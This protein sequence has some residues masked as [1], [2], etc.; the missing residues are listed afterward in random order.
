MGLGDIPKGQATLQ[1]RFLTAGMLISQQPWA[2]S[3]AQGLNMR[4]NRSERMVETSG[5][6]G[7]LREVTYIETDPP[8]FA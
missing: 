1:I 4:G 5:G 8:P 2:S 7:E 3:W 6:G